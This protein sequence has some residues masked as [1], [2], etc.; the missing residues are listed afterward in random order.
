MDRQC[1]PMVSVIMPVFNTG[2]YLIEAINSVLNQKT[3]S[4]CELPSFELIIVDDH[5]TDQKTIAILDAASISDSRIHVIANQRKKGAAGARN[6]GIMNARGT[7]IGFL[8]SDD[9]W[10]PNSLALRWH[11]ISKNVNVKWAGAHFRL[12]KPSFHLEGK[13]VFESSENLM[14]GFDEITD[15][16]EM[17]CLPQ[18]VGEF[19]NSCMIGIMT[20]L[21]QR[22]LIIEKG[23]FNEQLRRSEDY[24]LWFKCAFDN[25]LW[26]I[27]SDIAFYRIHSDS[28]THGNHPKYL[29]EDTMIEFL[30]KDPIGSMH[31]SMLTR[32]FDF[33]MQDQCYFYRGQKLFGAACQTALQWIS[34]RPLKLSAWKELVACGL[35]VG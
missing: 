23:M 3:V 8:D 1:A 2:A 35:R 33:V 21:I 16:P 26:M 18:P 34:K 14:V 5:S 13:P 19:A 12:L 24:H 11:S 30:L 29:Y 27:K 7:W 20:V 15:L 28:L 25:D 6:T 4:D 31:K 10:F 17:V 32:R 22:A 9:I